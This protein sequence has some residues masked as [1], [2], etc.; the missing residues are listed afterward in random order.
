MHAEP[1]PT[2]V[3]VAAGGDVRITALAPRL[4]RLEWAPG[5]AC[6]DRPSYA[7]PR[8]H[9][10]KPHSA[11]APTPLVLDTGAVQV[12]YTGGGAF[13]SAN[14]TIRFTLP[15]GAAMPEVRAM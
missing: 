8:R 15:E 10:A 12:A 3:D 9:I 6:D 4:I 5:G 1:L 7:F 14:L 13:S 11:A 2:P